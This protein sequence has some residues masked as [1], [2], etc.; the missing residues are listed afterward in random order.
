M[1]LNPICR[2]ITF[3]L[4]CRYLSCTTPS[5][6]QKQNV[7]LIGLPISMLLLSFS[8]N[9]SFPTLYLSSIL[10]QSNCTVGFPFLFQSQGWCLIAYRVL[11]AGSLPRHGLQLPLNWNQCSHTVLCL[12]VN[13]AFSGAGYLLYR[14]S[15]VLLPFTSKLLPLEGTASWCVKNRPGYRQT[16]T[17]SIVLHFP[18]WTCHQSTLSWVLFFPQGSI[19]F[20]TDII[21]T[22]RTPWMSAL[23]RSVYLFGTNSFLD[24][25]G[26]MS[27]LFHSHFN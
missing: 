17:V 14:I 5:R 26:I 10:I 4:K 7:K 21:N 6:K 11:Q 2:L 13:E 16:E 20:F 12:W 23:Y 25:L 1:W 22:F 9:S 3:P 27:F 24:H 19:C 18:G 8:R 15:H